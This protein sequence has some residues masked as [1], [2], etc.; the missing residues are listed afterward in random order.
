[1]HA[2]TPGPFGGWRRLAVLDSPG[3]RI[4]VRYVIPAIGPDTGV[5]VA[6]S[7]W[8]AVHAGQVHEVGDAVF[9][10]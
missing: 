8:R 10:T 3:C 1:M 9:H 4:V 6:Q 7:V 2:K 5:Q